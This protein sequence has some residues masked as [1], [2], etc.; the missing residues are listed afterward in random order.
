MTPDEIAFVTSISAH[1][2]IFNLSGHKATRHIIE[3]I[4]IGRACLE[5]ATSSA[6]FT[7]SSHL[8]FCI[9]ILL[10]PCTAATVVPSIPLIGC[11]LCTQVL[12]PS[13]GLTLALSDDAKE[14]MTRVPPKNDPVKY[15]LVPDYRYCISGLLRVALPAA[16]PQFLYLIVLGQ[17]MWE[18]EPSFVLDFCLHSID[19]GEIIEPIKPPTASILRCNALR[20]YSGPVTESAGT[21][22]LASFALCICVSS[23]SYV[24]RTESIRAEPPWKRNHLWLGSLAVS[25]ILVAGYLSL[26]LENGSMQA[27]GWSFYLLFVISP[28]ICLYCCEVAKK[29]DQTNERRAA[30]MRRLQ[31]ETRYVCFSLYIF[32]CYPSASSFSHECSHW[33]DWACG[34]PRSPHMWGHEEDLPRALI[35][36]EKRH[37]PAILS[38]GRAHCPCG[39]LPEICRET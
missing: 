18:L 12:V 37:F 28:F 2:S 38:D 4:R 36:Q 34:R 30:M 33:L 8:S 14:F 39:F 10:C 5:A 21:I 29:M 22:L 32:Q 7:L 16:L 13:I 20:D 26:F 15:S 19:G 3:I 1:S 25:F 17:L 35:A 31:F 24:F 23:A 6:S 27:L 9:F 11:F